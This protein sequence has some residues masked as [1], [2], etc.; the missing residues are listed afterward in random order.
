MDKEYTF[1]VDGISYKA[2]SAGYKEEGAPV[3]DIEDSEGDFIDSV[4]VHPKR[5]V[6]A[7]LSQAVYDNL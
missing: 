5:D 6:T 3:Y 1:T 2:V 4:A 7:Q